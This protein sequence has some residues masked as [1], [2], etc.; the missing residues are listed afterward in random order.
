MSLRLNVHNEVVHDLL[1]ITLLAV[2]QHH[3]YIPFVQR[4]LAMYSREL[5]QRDIVTAVGI[6][7]VAETCH[8]MCGHCATPHIIALRRAGAP[9]GMA[10]SFIS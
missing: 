1:L 7:M 10:R 3:N 4:L 2:T 9:L 8:C 6:P 5:Y